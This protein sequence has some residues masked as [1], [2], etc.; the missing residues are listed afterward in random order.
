MVLGVAF[1]NLRTTAFRNRSPG[2]VKREPLTRP[3][4]LKDW[5]AMV[6]HSAVEIPA[7]NTAI[8][9]CSAELSSVHET[10]SIANPIE[11]HPN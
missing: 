10:S 2:G 3:A 1:A 11:L 9:R 4:R 5:R 8:T 7:P 6:S